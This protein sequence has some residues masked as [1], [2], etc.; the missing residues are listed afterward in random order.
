MVICADHMIFFKNKHNLLCSGLLF[1]KNHLVSNYFHQYND[2]ISQNHLSVTDIVI[3]IAIDHLIWSNIET[4]YDYNQITPA[5]TP[6]HNYGQKLNI[7]LFFNL[8]LS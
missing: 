8:P 1:L 6:L 4:Q 3:L 5:S 7:K 2:I